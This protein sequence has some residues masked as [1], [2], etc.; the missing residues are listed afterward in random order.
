ML[1]SY[2]QSRG[3]AI[4]LCSE[5]STHVLKGE[6]VFALEQTAAALLHLLPATSVS[7]RRRLSHMQISR[8]DVD[9]IIEDLLGAGL[10]EE[11]SLL[12]HILSQAAS[13]S[14]RV[15][16]P[17]LHAVRRR[18]AVATLVSRCHYLRHKLE[19][20]EPRDTGCTACERG[21]TV[22]IIVY[23]GIG[24]MVLATPLLRCL[25]EANS[26]AAL[27]VLVRARNAAMYQRCSFIRRVVP[28]RGLHDMFRC[29]RG[30]SELTRDLFRSRY[31]T[32]ISFMEHFGGSCRWLSAKA[33]AYLTGARVRV[34]T[35]DGMCAS[36]GCLA[37]PLL[38]HPVAFRR[39][40]EVSRGARLVSQLGVK[41]PPGPLEVWY[42]AQDRHWARQVITRCKASHGE[43]P[44]VGIAPF[45]ARDKMWPLDYWAQLLR[46]LLNNTHCVGLVL[47]GTRD[48]NMAAVLNTLCQ[49]R[50]VNL[51]GQTPLPLFC[52]LIGQLDLLLSVDTG[53]AHIG[54]AHRLRQ[55]VLFG[56]VDPRKYGP[57]Q[58]PHSRVLRAPSGRLKDLSVQQVHCTVH[59]LLQYS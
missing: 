3:L 27:D 19:R 54:A 7:L 43:S 20:L 16:V 22:L 11:Q 24:D 28:F 8:Q 26:T 18:W 10:I 6:D 2:R 23:G 32:V 39:E 13:V 1:I 45:T 53:A 9:A 56:P 31:G 12:R 38:T 17:C 59:Q 30:P 35:W 50:L 34:G 21:D 14:R 15:R 4:P 44:V 58:N 46:R 52:A 49:N 37:K 33:I 55:V 47:G 51:A 40:H 25:H 41:A 42:G 29:H 5:D 48:R 36:A 57:W